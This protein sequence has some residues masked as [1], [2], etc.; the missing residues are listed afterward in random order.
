MLD[1]FLH[2]KSEPVTAIFFSFLQGARF[3]HTKHL[4]ATPRAN[5]SPYSY[6]I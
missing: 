2:L 3:I 6:L 5:C 4:S 1:L